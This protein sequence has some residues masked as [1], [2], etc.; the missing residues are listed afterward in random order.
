MIELN[1]KENAKKLL[2]LSKNY[3]LN[4]FSQKIAWKKLLK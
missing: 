2:K 4:L 3:N 1:S